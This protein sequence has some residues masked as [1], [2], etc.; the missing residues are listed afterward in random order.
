MANPTRAQEPRPP[1]GSRGSC[2]GDAQSRSVGLLRLAGGEEA[3]VPVAGVAGLEPGRL[4][5]GGGGTCR[6]LGPL[7]VAPVLWRRSAGTG[8]PCTVAILQAGEDADGVRVGRPLGW[9]AAAGDLTGVGR[10]GQ[11]DRSDDTRSWGSGWYGDAWTPLS[12]EI[13]DSSS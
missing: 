1:R 13:L 5:V 7:D 2:S 4:E 12:S 11:C 6:P 3:P 8:E 9:L 10:G